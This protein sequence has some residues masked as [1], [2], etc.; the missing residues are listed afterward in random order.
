[1]FWFIYHLP[2]WF[3]AGGTVAAPFVWALMMLPVAKRSTKAVRN[4]NIFFLLIA[5]GGILY[6]TLFRSSSGERECILMPFHIFIEARGQR[7]FYRSMLM[8][9]T[10]FT[11][12]GIALPFALTDLKKPAAK[13]ILLACLLSIMIEVLQFILG[14]G[15][16]ETDDVLC[17]T[18]GAAIGS[19]SYVV[20]VKK[21][22][23]T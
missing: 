22:S 13:A 7:D 16:C 12:L 23:K 20:S 6:V 3:V 18:L 14:T 21:I 2:L 5:L 11:P 8:N 15:R 4:L 1:M 19:L 10:L 17:N 9:I